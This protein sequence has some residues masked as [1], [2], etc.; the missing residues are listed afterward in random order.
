VPK[1]KSAKEFFETKKGAAI[2]KHRILEQYLPV[3]VSKTGSTSRG[4]RVVYVDGFAGEGVYADESEGS[5]LLAVRT[6]ERLKGI[7]NVSFHFIENDPESV[8]KLKQA[9]AKVD[10][11]VTIHP[12]D[13]QDCVPP[14]ISAASGVPAFVFLDPFGHKG[15]DFDFAAKILRRPGAMPGSISEAPT[16][17]LLRFSLDSL[18]RVGGLLKRPPEIRR[19]AE[20]TTLAGMDR[21]M[22]GAWWQ[23]LWKDQDKDA[24]R[25]VRSEFRKRLTAASG[26]DYGH[27]D[28]PVPPRWNA[29]AEYRLQF[30]S[31]HPH[32][33]WNFMEAVSRAR[34]YQRD[35]MEDGQ[36]SLLSAD[37]QFVDEIEGCVRKVCADGA[38]FSVINNL[39]KV[40]GRSLG[41][42]RGTH[43]TKALKR[44]RDEGLLTVAKGEWAPARVITPSATKPK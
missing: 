31:G 20:V 44:L 43:V 34:E 19:R 5:P 21:A 6:L 1:K 17:L 16:E 37:D 15:M 7:R 25:E 35:L 39:D 32:G 27:F 8:D 33:Y 2:L 40:F 41:L 42:A 22:G 9:L 28:I 38:S 36:Q 18:R 4:N 3:F 13:A 11:D 24:E 14:I 23:P 12:G 10:G 30:F 26:R 29:N